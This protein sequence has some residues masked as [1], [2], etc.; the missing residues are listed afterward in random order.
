MR[1]AYPPPGLADHPQMLA[2]AASSTVRMDTPFGPAGLPLGSSSLAKPHPAKSGIDTAS[3]LAIAF[4]NR[5]SG[6]I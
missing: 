4:L 2:H 5:F 6:S 1:P 3:I